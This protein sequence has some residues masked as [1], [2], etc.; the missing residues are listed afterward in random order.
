MRLLITADLHFNHPRSKPLA[1][2]LIEQMNRA[3]GDAVLLIGDTAVADGQ[4]LEACLSRFNIKGPKLFLCGNHELWTKGTD[5]HHLFTDELPRRV[6]ALGWQWLE[7]D[8]FIARGFAIVGTIGWYDYS[9]ASPRLEIPRRFYEAKMS[10]G[11]AAYLR[12]DDLLADRSDLSPA[13]LEIVAR[14]NDGKFVKLHRSDEA[15]LDECLVQL[16]NHLE[17]VRCVPQVL[18]ATHH[19]PLRELLPPSHYNQLEF[20]KAYLGSG[21]IGNVIRRS[22]NV[23]QVFCGHSHFGAR[24]TLGEIEAINIGSSY[25]SKKFETLELPD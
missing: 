11:A 4:E 15:F 7:T 22:P 20:V 10:P 25:R 19:L 12:R 1:I 13:A 23:R 2:E 9:F 16:S 3:G 24:V 21:R 17:Q 5:S 14:W 18:V 8:P 6:A